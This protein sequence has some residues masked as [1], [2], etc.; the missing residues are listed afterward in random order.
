MKQI[1]QN[2]NTG[3]TTLTE[4]PVPQ[5][6]RGMVL[7][8][9]GRTLISAGTERMLV[10]FSRGG[11]AGQGAGSAGQGETGIGQD[12]DRGSASHSG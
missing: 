11:A 1:L 7:I 10:E 12:P 9:T 6:G 5:P 2:L 8:R 3:E 4:V